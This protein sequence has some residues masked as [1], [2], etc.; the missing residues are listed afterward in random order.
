MSKPT[1]VQEHQAIVALNEY[2]EGGKQ[3]PAHVWIPR[4]T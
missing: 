1:Y 2:S 3:A 4:L